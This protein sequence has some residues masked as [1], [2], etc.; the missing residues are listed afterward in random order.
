MKYF[1]NCINKPKYL[2][3]HVLG[4][5]KHR[6]LLKFYFIHMF[7]LNIYIYFINRFATFISK[8]MK[9]FA[10][11]NDIEDGNFLVI[12]FMTIINTV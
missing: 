8:C 4:L 2:M 6:D 10:T 11:L 5:Q 7:S 9:S 12:L 1:D 3:E